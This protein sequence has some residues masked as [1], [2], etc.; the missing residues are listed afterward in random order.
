MARIRG[1]APA[2]AA[3]PAGPA[4]EFV[5][6]L[7]TKF[8]LI[9]PGSFL[10]GYDTRCPA[11]DPFTAVNEKAACEKQSNIPELLRPQQKVTLSKP[12]YL[13]VY[14][15]TQEEYVRVVG[16]NP[17]TFQAEL[18]GNPRRHPVDHANAKAFVDALNRLENTTAYRLPTEAEWQYA[19]T[20]GGLEPWQP[21][22]IDEIA[23]NARNSGGAKGLTHPVGQ[24]KPNSWGLY[25][26]FGNVAEPVADRTIRRLETQPV[27]D[28]VGVEANGYHS[29][30]WRAFVRGGDAGTAPALINPHERVLGTLVGIR[31]ARDV[32]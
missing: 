29:T 19:A 1:N 10:M 4:P 8:V 23:W 15:I 20:A 6:T 21:E 31:L 5:N 11:D 28:P 16:T 32:R 25:D 18:V 22:Q 7:G 9:R 13:S 30:L 12:Y 2:A 17:S 26:M 14:E 27:M 3:T 24:K